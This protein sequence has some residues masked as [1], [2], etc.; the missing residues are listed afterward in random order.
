MGCYSNHNK[1]PLLLRK[2]SKPRTKKVLHTSGFVN[3]KSNCNATPHKSSH[4]AIEEEVLDCFLL[5]TK[6]TLRTP[7]PPSLHQVIFSEHH[8]I[9][10]EPHESYTILRQ[11]LGKLQE[12]KYALPWAKEFYF[13]Q[14]PSTTIT[15]HAWCISPHTTYRDYTFLFQNICHSS[16]ST[17]IPFIMYVDIIYI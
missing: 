14:Y 11:N 1:V 7:L 3:S 17:Y 13:I 6:A 5:R 12:S 2:A 16:F 15:L 9:F 4:R 8:P 10:K